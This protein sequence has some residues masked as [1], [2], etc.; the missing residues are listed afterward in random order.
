MPDALHVLRTARSVRRRLDFE[1]PIEREVLEGGI[2]AGGRLKR[3]TMGRG[4]EIRNLNKNI[5]III[6]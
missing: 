5:R 2:D 1:R 4:E 6:I 3:K